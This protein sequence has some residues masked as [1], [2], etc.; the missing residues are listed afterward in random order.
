MKKTKNNSFVWLAVI[1]LVFFAV[2]CGGSKEQT[3]DQPGVTQT[4][5][6]A[7]KANLAKVKSILPKKL[8]ELGLDAETLAKCEAAY[9][10]I[11]T[12]EVVAQRTE[13][14][15]KFKGIAKDSAQYAQLRKE[16]TEKMKPY[17]VAF[18]KKLRKI[19]TKEQQEKYFAKPAK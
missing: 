19:L 17:N 16:L 7:A 4:A 11:F 3:T 1:A 10:E 14:N 13:L 18:N 6:D 12:P 15:K 5:A 2:Q 9:K 8:Q